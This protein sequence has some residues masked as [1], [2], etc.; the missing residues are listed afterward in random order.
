MKYELLFP[1]LDDK[2]NYRNLKIDDESIHYISTYKQCMDII[3]ITNDSLDDLNL[4]LRNMTITDMTAGV[5]GNAIS[6]AKKCKFVNAIEIDKQRCE[7]L[8][9]NANIYKTKN[10]NVINDNSI[11]AINELSHNIIF[12]DPPWGGC[13]YK[14]YDSINIHFEQYNMNE[15]VNALFTGKI[16]KCIPKMVILKLPKNFDVKLFK[17]SSH[18]YNFYVIKK[19]IIAVF[20]N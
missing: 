8:Q 15:L 6:F 7:Y 5:G 11:A 16:N 13:D 9:H 4:H 10:I 1:Y 14:K 17:Q 19:M 12:I 20:V 2:E 3:A 18:K